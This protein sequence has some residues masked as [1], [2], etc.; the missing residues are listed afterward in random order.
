MAD[1][2]YPLVKDGLEFLK[3]SPESLKDTYDTIKSAIKIT[4]GIVSVV[5]AFSSIVDL[6]QSLG[7]LRPEKSEQEKK[8]NRMADQIAAIYDYLLRKEADTQVI[9]A[10]TWRSS[11][12]RTQSSTYNATTVSRGNNILQSLYNETLELD[13]KLDEMMSWGG[14]ITFASTSYNQHPQFPTWLWNWLNAAKYPFMTSIARGAAFDYTPQRDLRDNIWDPGYFIDVLVDAIHARVAALVALEPAFRSTGTDRQRLQDIAAYLGHFIQA[15]RDNL[16][17]AMPSAGITP[18]WPGKR[19]ILRNPYSGDLAADGIVLGVFDPV[20]GASNVS[21]WK[22]LD[23]RN[24]TAWA[25]DVP[26]NHENLDVSLD[27]IGGD[28]RQFLDKFKVQNP[29][30]PSWVPDYA[31]A[32][33]AATSEQARRLTEL[34]PQTLIG[35]LSEL[36]ETIVTLSQPPVGSEFVDCTE[37]TFHLLG[38]RTLVLPYLTVDLG[39]FKQYSPDPAKTYAARRIGQRI[40][41]KFRFRIAKRADFSGVQLGYR[42]SINGLTRAGEITDGAELQRLLTICEY[43]QDDGDTVFTPLE[44]PITLRVEKYDCIQRFPLNSS[45]EEAYERDGHAPVGDRI[46]LN[47]RVGNATLNLRVDYLEDQGPM[48]HWQEVE[49]TLQTPAGLDG[50]DLASY[51]VGVQVWETH[52]GLVSGEEVLADHVATTIIPSFLLVGQDFFDDLYRAMMN[53]IKA[54][55]HAELE[56]RKSWRDL[57]DELPTQPFPDPQYGFLRPTLLAE[58]S[59][60]FLDA[61]LATNHPEV[62]RAIRRYEPPQDI[63]IPTD[64]AIFARHAPG[65][66]ESNANPAQP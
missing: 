34:L 60:N 50:D 42:I 18:A 63:E 43:D 54:K 8:I 19:G 53:M 46:L 7:I 45:Q 35:K 52:M 38:I 13:E 25:W 10:S 15:Y 14:T 3:F 21:T 48:V 40:E 33:D 41:K 39:R 44:T 12:R 20:T 49:V 30:E 59:L 23:A 1:D 22:G 24:D 9:Q 26:G 31:S 57:L 51:V 4:S 47:P 36:R 5:G 64:A 2:E 62:I 65:A 58:H 32:L 27:N 56:I 55:V 16:W 6:A 11:F 61:A 17:V 37:P 66:L 29:Y 28:P